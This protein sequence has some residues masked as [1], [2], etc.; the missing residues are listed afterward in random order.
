MEFLILNHLVHEVTT[1]PER[2]TL[3]YTFVF[4]RLGVI[5]PRIICSLDNLKVGFLE[6]HSILGCGAILPN[7]NLPTFR[8][9]TVPRYS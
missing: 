7:R 3:K 6:A 9:I 4:I 2:S 5:C 1:R 8:G